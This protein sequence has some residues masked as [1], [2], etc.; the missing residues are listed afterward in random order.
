MSEE[1]TT[2]QQS[3][4]PTAGPPEVEIGTMRRLVDAL[5]PDS[6]TPAP[7]TF[8]RVSSEMPLPTRRAT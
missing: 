6:D 3:T 5:A 2:A 1:A 4:V 7:A 8:D